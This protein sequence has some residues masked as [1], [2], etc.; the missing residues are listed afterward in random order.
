MND[1]R[2]WESGAPG[3]LHNQ[4]VLDIRAKPGENFITY[5]ETLRLYTPTASFFFFLKAS[6]SDNQFEAFILGQ[7]V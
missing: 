1:W 2:G 5:M 6:Y 7:C 3:C 4:T